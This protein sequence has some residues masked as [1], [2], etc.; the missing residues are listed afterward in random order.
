MFLLESPHRG[1]SKGHT[2]HTIIKIK[3]NVILNYPKSNNVCSCG[4]FSSGFKNE[5]ETAV[6]NEPSVFEPLKFLCSKDRY[7]EATE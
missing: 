6:V 2:Q 4:N 7:F 5:F 1:D 3:K